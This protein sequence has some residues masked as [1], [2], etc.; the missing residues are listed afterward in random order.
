MSGSVRRLAPQEDSGR[1]LR[2]DD[3]SS[4]GAKIALSS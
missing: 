2:D 3:E 1:C 4:G